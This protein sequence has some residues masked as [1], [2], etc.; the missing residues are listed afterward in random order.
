M[1]EAMRKLQEALVV[2]VKD[3]PRVACEKLVELPIADF[4]F[5]PVRVPAGAA[6]RSLQVTEAVSPK[7]ETLMGFEIVLSKSVPP[8]AEAN[9]ESTVKTTVLTSLGA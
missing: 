5:Y 7:E 9:G 4:T 1:D 3:G 6:T 8:S 2:F